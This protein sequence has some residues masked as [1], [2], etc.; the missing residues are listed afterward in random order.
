MWLPGNVAAA[1]GENGD[2]LGAVHG[3]RH[4]R[5]DQRGARIDVVDDVP[6]RVVEHSQF[7]VNAALDDDAAAR[8]EHAAV[9]HE[10]GV[11][12]LPDHLV[13]QRIPGFE[14][15][16]H[17]EARHL[18]EVA[19]QSEGPQAGRKRFRRKQLVRESNQHPWRST[20][21]RVWPRRCL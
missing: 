21:L 20:L 15:R 16:M 5:G 8:R 18:L 19:R 11:L 14:R 6:G 13:C 10:A 12:M 1:A 9:I 3:V 17:F 7:A 2:V 4:R